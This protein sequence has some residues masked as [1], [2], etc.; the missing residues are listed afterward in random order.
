VVLL[1]P[2]MDV[3]DP[4]IMPRDMRAKGGRRPIE[5]KF[6]NITKLMVRN[7][8]MFMLS[9]RLDKPWVGEDLQ[10]KEAP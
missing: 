5:N 6:I 9:N 2:A 3:H 4:T 8:Q 7:Y 1:D 10:M